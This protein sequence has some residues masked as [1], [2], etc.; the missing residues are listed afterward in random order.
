MFCFWATLGLHAQELTVKSM[1]LAA[2]DLSASTYQRPDKN[3]KPCALV[4]VQL[5]R[6]GAVFEGNVIGETEYKTNEYWVYMSAGSYMLNIKHPNFL[7]LMVNF[8]DYDIRSVESLTTYNLIIALPAFINED[9]PTGSQPAHQESNVS[10]SNTQASTAPSSTYARPDVETITFDHVSFNMVHVAGG[11]FR[12]G[13]ADRIWVVDDKEPVH[14]VTLSDYSI[15]E[16]E[17]TQ[18]LWEA[19]MGNNPSSFKGKSLP[20]EQVSWEDCQ[21]FIKKLNKKTGRTFRLLTEAEWEFAARGGSE[22]QKSMYSG[23]D[24]I[25]DVAWYSGNSQGKTHDVGTKQANELGLYDMSGNVQEWCSDWKGNYDNS[26]QTNPK[27]PSSGNDHVHRG[28]SWN[29]EAK[30]CR[31]SFREASSPSN[32]NSAIGLRLAL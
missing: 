20:V 18:A 26:A 31:P 16:T 21:K 7:S 11:S 28:G 23:G 4:K 1:E 10:T 27:G 3:G 24:N 30:N 17:V 15:G 22:N 14:Q 25:S 19:V 29:S 5:V 32:R 2:M 8:R 6:P 9:T 13:N 12:M